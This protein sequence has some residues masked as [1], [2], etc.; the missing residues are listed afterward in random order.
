MTFSNPGSLSYKRWNQAAPSDKGG[1]AL[2]SASVLMAPRPIN[3]KQAG[4]SPLQAQLPAR[5]S[6]REH[7]RLQRDFHRRPKI[8]HQGQKAAFA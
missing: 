5:V 2:T 3:S 4:Y 7:H 6:C 8:T 1:V